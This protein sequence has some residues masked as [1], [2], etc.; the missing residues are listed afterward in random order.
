MIENIF[1]KGRIL[2]FS[3]VGRDDVVALWNVCLKAY[4]PECPVS[5][6]VL[7]EGGWVARLRAYLV[8]NP[9]LDWVIY[10]LDDNWLLRPPHCT[11][12][13][14][15]KHGC[16]RRAIDFLMENPEIAAVRDE[17]VVGPGV[18]PVSFAFSEIFVYAEGP[19]RHYF[20]T[21]L[22]PTLWRTEALLETTNLL[23]RMSAE[24]DLAWSGAWNWEMH[25]GCELDWERW[26][27]A[28]VSQDVWLREG[29]LWAVRNACKQGLW[30]RESVSQ[31]R[32]V[33]GITS[34]VRFSTGTMVELAR[35]VGV[36]TTRPVYSGPEDDWTLDLVRAQGPPKPKRNG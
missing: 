29:E 23:D 36:T 7:K 2:L 32:Y 5:I 3:D 1:D 30:S 26:K 25:S 22:R 6:E 31:L 15:Y 19:R 9:G 35:K 10:W 34:P 27:V 18:H 13:G 33:L 8:E 21:G 11:P 20:A 16:F 14:Y 4:W 17:A 24:Q 12:R 28:A